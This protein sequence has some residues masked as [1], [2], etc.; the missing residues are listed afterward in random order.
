MRHRASTETGISE[1]HGSHSPKPA[2]AEPAKPSQSRA[3]KPG[4]RGNCPSPRLS[5]ELSKSVN[6]LIFD[7]VSTPAPH[8]TSSQL[9]Q[10]LLLSLMD[11]LSPLLPHDPLQPCHILKVQVH[12][13]PWPQLPIPPFPPH[14]R[15]LPSLLPC[16]GEHLPLAFVH[17]QPAS[18][19][20][21]GLDPRL[22]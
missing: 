10:A 6:N 4:L 19:M 18:Q 22:P 15:G 7:D 5:H 9:Y 20:P 3:G 14:L 2:R 12:C 13:H 21:P 8:L 1:C 16:H 17:A 11:L